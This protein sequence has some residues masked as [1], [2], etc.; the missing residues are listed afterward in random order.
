M[1]KKS[2]TQRARA[3]A[4][5]AQNKAERAEAA[6]QVVEKD[7][8]PEAQEEPKRKFF[9]RKS[10]DAGEAA[11]VAESRNTKKVASSDASKQKAKASDQAVKKAEKPKKKPGR[12]VSF[13][14]DVKAEM[15]RVTWP[16]R[17][18][19]LRWTGVVIA[20]LVFFGVFV[21]ILDNLIITPVLV[22]VAGLGA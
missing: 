19:V 2:K 15:K 22:F 20:A 1:A 21:A 3:Q 17:T 9:S 11:S 5:R 8:Q 18:D 16:T 7:S 12:I 14:K 6:A 10:K 13:F 4:R